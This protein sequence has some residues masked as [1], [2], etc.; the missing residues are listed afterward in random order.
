MPFRLWELVPLCRTRTCMR[1]AIMVI[2]Y[3]RDEFNSDYAYSN[4]YVD[5][6]HVLLFI[7]PD[8]PSSP[9]SGL[10]LTRYFGS[11]VGSMVARV[12]WNMGIGSSDEWPR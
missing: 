6:V 1:R 9:K 5:P 2:H 11:P 12:G 8:L 7:N 4:W 10:P 3:F